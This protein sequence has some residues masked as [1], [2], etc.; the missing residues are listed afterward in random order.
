[1]K[2]VRFTGALLL[3]LSTACSNT[4]TSGLPAAGAYRGTYEVPVSA[5]LAAAAVFAVP[6]VEWTVTE[7]AVKLEYDLPL[8]LVGR[9]LRVEFTGAT[10]ASLSGAP[11]TATCTLG[12]AAVSCHEI[13]AGLHPVSPDY[14][15]IEQVAKTDYQG[16]ISQRLDVAKQFAADPIGIVHIDLDAPADDAH[17]V[18]TEGD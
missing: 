1:M 17:E 10:P 9:P 15:V 16:P 2:N 11:G 7:G 5:D 18:E 8:G 4:G 12:A 6:K 3:V 13:M 14:A